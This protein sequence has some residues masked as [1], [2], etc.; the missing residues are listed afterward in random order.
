MVTQTTNKSPDEV[1][2]TPVRLKDVE[3]V[4]DESVLNAPEASIAGR[5]MECPRQGRNYLP[6]LAPFLP[7]L[8]FN[9]FGLPRRCGVTGTGWPFGLDAGVT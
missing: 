9:G 1:V 4:E 6:A 7:T 2:L 8:R 5:V 3:E